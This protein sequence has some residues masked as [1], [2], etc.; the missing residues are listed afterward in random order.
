MWLLW[1]GMKERV[2][3]GGEDDGL[4]G[5]VVGRWLHGD[6]LGGLRS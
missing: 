6:F 5:G 1:V 2:S 4:M 3:V